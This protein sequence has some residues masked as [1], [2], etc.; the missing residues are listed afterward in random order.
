MLVFL[1]ELGLIIRWHK[2]TNDM[3]HSQEMLNKW[4]AADHRYSYKSV[5]NHLL[6]AQSV[7]YCFQASRP[8][9]KYPC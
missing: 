5:L 1:R 6:P 3:S 9:N 2:T 4:L 8:A 7:D